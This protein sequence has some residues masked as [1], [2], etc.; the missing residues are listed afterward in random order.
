MY[1]YVKGK[2]VE[3]APT[4]AIIETGG[5]A[6]AI[7]ISL[8][9]F[10]GLTGKSEAVLYLHHV[11]REDAQLLYGFT[12]KEERGIFRMLISVSGIGANT[13]RLI[14]SSLSPEET[15]KAILGADV[16]TLQGIKGIGG[17]TAQRLIVDLKDK[18]GKS[19]PIDEIFTQKY[20]TIREESLSALVTL[21]FSKN[22]VEK[23]LDKII[24]QHKD[25]V[26]AV[27]DLIKGALKDL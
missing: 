13:A 4:H 8:H 27:E 15:R 10:S 2:L 12:D 6:Y 20:N 19:V 14:L 1:E 16:R 18:L 5:I 21:G 7:Q 23:V 22:S 11:I 26:L 3:L 25:T 24:A 9:T 17:K